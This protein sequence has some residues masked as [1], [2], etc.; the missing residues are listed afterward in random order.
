MIKG[1]TIMTHFSPQNIHS[2]TFRCRSARLRILSRQGRP[3][4]AEVYVGEFEGRSN[5][6]IE[7]VDGLDT[8]LSR[9]DKWI[10]NISTQIGCPIACLF[11]DAGGDYQGNLS[12]DEML[13]QAL[14]LSSRHPEFV[15][16]CAKLKIHFAR[17]GEP[18]LNDSVPE[19]I[20]QLSESFGNPNLWC[21]LATTA[22]AGREAWFER[23][24]EV[25]ES[26]F[27]GRFQLQFS[28][29]STDD[30]ER[31]RL[32]PARLWGL[33]EI[34]RY[35]EKAFRPGDRRVILNFALADGVSFDIGRIKS[36]FAPEVF[37]VKLTPVNP[38]RRGEEAGLRTILRSERNRTETER[39]CEELC[40]SG[41]DVVISVGDGRE[42]HI[43]SNCGQSVLR[44]HEDEQDEPVRS[45]DASQR[46]RDPSFNLNS[47]LGRILP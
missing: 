7:F 5:S 3:D 32:M 1:K 15:R 21:C 31:A 8:R 41:Y 40:V 4:V 19:T 28:V 26:H 25:K 34:A 10:I 14:Y 9:K 24:L 44:L 13:A 30:A 46:R 16:T 42:D 23:L 2:E 27:R 17:M 39:A 43:G 18:A 45:S 20:A 35:G 12:K 6:R 22:P 36:C 38:T 37:A 11:C 47:Y 33:E 29:N